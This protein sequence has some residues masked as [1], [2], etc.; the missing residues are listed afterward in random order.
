MSTTDT[1]TPD[2]DT[3][4][5]GDGP[6]PTGHGFELRRT[7][8]WP[9]V[10]GGAVLVVAVTAAIVVPRLGGAATANS[11]PGATLYVATAEGNAREQ[12]LIEYVA[13]EIAPDHG[14]TVAFRGL[15]DSNTINRAV[16]DGEVAGTIY[17]HE[18]WLGQVLQANPDFRETAA[19]PVFRWGFGLWSSQ[20]DT[21]EEIPDG[22][23]ISLYSDPANEA[24]GLWVLE[25]AG[26]ITLADGVDRWTAT[27]A[28]IAENPKN[29]EFVLLDFGA[30]S[31]A[32][33]DLDGAVGY[34]EYYVSAK[35]PT[36]WQIFAPPAPD[37]FASQL[38]VGTEWIDEPNI[39]ALIAAFQDPRVQEYLATDPAVQGVLLPLDAR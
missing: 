39:Q 2:L 37:E 16:N 28:D 26:L 31:R 24:Q 3:D 20:W 36:E 8:R 38:T 34:T 1:T 13:A 11:T 25:R 12:A 19:T 18:L 30:Q 9:W 23:T 27:Q 4:P 22:A 14:I 33:P 32:L 17:Q 29:L 15:S 7:R 5:S 21:V 6:D 35:V 10:V